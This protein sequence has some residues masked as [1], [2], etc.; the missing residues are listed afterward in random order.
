MAYEAKAGSFSLFKNDR[1]EKDSH[2]DYRGDGKDLNG[3]DVWVSAWLKDSAKGKFMS[4]SF[5]LKE[6]KAPT[7]AQPK[8]TAEQ[9]FDDMIP[10]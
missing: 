1:K 5:Q 7:K 2:P 6:Q 4:C 9:D 3:N 8:Q 10:F